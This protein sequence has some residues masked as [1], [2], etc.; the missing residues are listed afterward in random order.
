MKCF[1][2]VPL[3][4]ILASLRRIHAPPKFTKLIENLHTNRHFHI[5]TISGLT[6]PKPQTKLHTIRNK[7]LIGQVSTAI[8][9]SVLLPRISHMLQAIAVTRSQFQTIH[10]ILSQLARR[11]HLIGNTIAGAQRHGIPTQRIPSNPLT[12]AT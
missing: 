11:K 5:N 6:E 9:N 4:R 3:E 8:I 12:K 7:Y 10:Y 1:D 2:T